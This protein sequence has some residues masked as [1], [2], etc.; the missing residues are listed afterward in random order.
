MSTRSLASIE[1][2]KRASET[3]T[4]RLT[5][6]RRVVVALSEVVNKEAIGP[7]MVRPNQAFDGLKPLEVIERG[8][9]DRIW[10]MIF[11]LRSGV[12]F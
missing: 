12:P 2:G 4:R 5:E 11:Q 1:Q 7:W 9:A 6:I 10:Q 8:E 3:V